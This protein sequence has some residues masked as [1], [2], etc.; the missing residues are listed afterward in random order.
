MR[1]DRVN[2]VLTRAGEGPAS[3][4]PHNPGSGHSQS[5]KRVY[6]TRLEAAE[7]AAEDLAEP[8]AGAV[9]IVAGGWAAKVSTIAM[10]P[11]VQAAIYLTD[12]E[13]EQELL[14]FRAA[15]LPDDKAYIEAVEDLTTTLLELDREVVDL[16]RNIDRDRSKAA[17]A[18]VRARDAKRSAEQRYRNA[19]D[20]TP[21][22]ADAENQIRDA[23]QAIRE[24]DDTLADCDAALESIEH[25]LL[26]LTKSLDALGVAED[27]LADFYSVIYALLRRGERLPRNGF[28]VTPEGGGDD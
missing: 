12:G 21:A 25:T 1:T 23:E 7:Q 2:R 3:Q 18:K 14:L 8:G 17:T 10:A 11:V 26:A 4:S 9:E 24:A 27:D 15:P 19:A 22:K 6:A 13:A 16:A 5:P 28:L 20:N